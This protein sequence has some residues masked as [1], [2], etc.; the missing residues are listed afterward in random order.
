ML[1]AY[2]ALLARPG[3]PSLALACLL[4]WLSYCGYALGLVLA[5]HGATSSFADAGA[6]VAAFSAGSGLVAPARGR[7]VDRRGPGALRPLALGHVAGAAVLLLGCRDGHQL[8]PILA[9]AA[10]AGVSAPPLIATARSMWTTVGGELARTGHALNAALADGAQIASPLLVAGLTAVE[11]AEIA[12]AVMVAGA[13]GTAWLLG[14]RRAVPV[15]PDR[16]KRPDGPDRGR[17]SVRPG[18][19]PAWGSGMGT[20]LAG[21]LA[22]GAWTAG[23][24][25]S[26]T[27]L[28]A[29]HGAGELAA[30]P[31]AAAAAGSL[32]VALWSGTGQTSRTA[33]GRYLAGW[34]LI[35]V[36]LPLTLISPSIAAVAAVLIPVGAG[37]GLVN[38]ALFELLDSLAP[39]GRAIEAF[40]WLTTAN[41]A[42][43]AGGAALAGRL[44]QSGTAPALLLVSA[45]AAAGAIATFARR[46]TLGRSPLSGSG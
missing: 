28:A 45:I 26:V 3:A 9:G 41:A 1:P 13:A 34:V 33:G 8:A 16:P 10:V 23:L 12:L 44:A 46:R 25:V 5:V 31:L 14:G 37:F 39:P 40:T 27:A 2:R 22:I 17:R 30:V 43:A 29:S 21:D 18:W 7:L 42:G 32:V 35:A 19:G 38:V 20:V 6:A 24:E 36:T 4:G 11:S 15:A